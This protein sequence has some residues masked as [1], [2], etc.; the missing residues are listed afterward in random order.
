MCHEKEE[1]LSIVEASWHGRYLQLSAYTDEYIKQT[2]ALAEEYTRNLTLIRTDKQ[3]LQVSYDALHA[4]L[5]Q[6]RAN[7]NLLTN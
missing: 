6:C 4:E 1:K 2:A 7:N 3:H 5:Q